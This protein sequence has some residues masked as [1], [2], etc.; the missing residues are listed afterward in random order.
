M[1]HKRHKLSGKARLL[2]ERRQ[3]ARGKLAQRAMYAAVPVAG[4][5]ITT[6]RRDGQ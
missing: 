5:T 6:N 4:L 1:S 2:H 3:A